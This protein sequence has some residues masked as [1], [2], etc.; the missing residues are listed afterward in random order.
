MNEPFLLTVKY[1]GSEHEL[2]ARFERWGYTHRIAVLI[3]EETV[4]FEPD[5][6]GS[7]RALGNS[8]A[9]VGL[10]QAIAE[11]LRALQS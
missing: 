7:Y 9:P 10:M 4:I 11:K 3:D 6:E 8:T 2:K 1:A 5:E